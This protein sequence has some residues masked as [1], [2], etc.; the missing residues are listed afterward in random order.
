MLV[1]AAI[2]F[3]IAIVAG[4]FGFRSV[5]G[6]ATQVAKVLF[7]LF[8]VIFIISLLMGL[9]NRWLLTFLRPTK[10]PRGCGAFH[11]GRLD[12]FRTFDWKNFKNHFKIAS[13]TIQDFT[14]A[15][16]NRL[17]S[18]ERVEGQHTKPE[19]YFSAFSCTSMIAFMIT[20][21]MKYGVPSVN[22]HHR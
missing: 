10:K 5:E 22:M 9:F 6:A 11:W 12:A 4:I 7:F 20:I 14:P 2:F 1:W 8:L 16:K 17:Q 18:P 21:L 13:S 3:I 19:A 15:W